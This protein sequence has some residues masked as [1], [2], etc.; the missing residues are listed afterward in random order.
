MGDFMTTKSELLQKIA[1]GE[2]SF[3]EF[4]ER[5]DNPESIAG[6]IVA[7]ANMDGGKI[8][9]G[10]RDDGII[11]GVEK[12]RQLEQNLMNVCRNNCQPAI[13]PKISRIEVDGKLLLVLEITGIF[14]KPYRTSGGRYYLRVGS[15]K[16]DITREELARLIQSAGLVQ[17]DEMPIP[18]T[19]LD[20]LDIESFEEY[21]QQ[22]FGE[23]I[24]DVNIPPETLLK[25]MRLMHA[26]G[27]LS[28][29]GL[30]FFGK[31][32]Q[33]F[34]PYT[35]LSAVCFAGEQ[36]CEE[37]IDRKEI[38]GRMPKMV[39]EIEIFLKRNTRI[40]AQ[41][42][43]FRRTDLPQY[44]MLAL[45][46]AV[47]NALAHRDYSI[48]GAQIRV[49]IFDDRVEVISPGKLPNT[50]TVENLRYGVHYERNPLICRLL[51]H[52]GYMSSIGTGIP[53]LIIRLSKQLSGKEPKFEVNGEQFRVTV[54]GAL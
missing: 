38:E 18:N 8:L 35:R 21:Y 50:I 28:L 41:I 31:Q 5:F 34:L 47:I 12:A 27:S 1:A 19:N 53:R 26:D 39:E 4:K 2:D 14:D 54:W 48:R 9:F 10:V 32:P 37:F 43:G 15:T 51:S 11:V 40:A 23:P 7:F 25:N 22:Q 33:L 20:D 52:F 16:R 6:E 42:K 24:S 17:Y 36:I 3:T 45:R 30:L 13:L 44:D 49:F 29:G 46:E